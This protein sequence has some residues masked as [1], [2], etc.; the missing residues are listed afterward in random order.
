M[1]RKAL[2]VLHF[3]LFQFCFLI[4]KFDF[5][6]E[7][8]DDTQ[9]RNRAEI[10]LLCV[11]EIVMI[12]SFVFVSDESGD[13]K[14]KERIETFILILIWMREMYLPKEYISIHLI[15]EFINISSLIE[16]INDRIIEDIVSDLIQFTY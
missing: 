7:P 16:D 12:S 3:T 11:L 10:I 15:K 14:A 1:A 9:G 8:Y 13:T 4:R 2:F 5:A 6:F